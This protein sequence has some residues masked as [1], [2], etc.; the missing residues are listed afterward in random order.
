MTAREAARS[1]LAAGKALT[2]IRLSVI[3]GCD[4]RYCANVLA[5]M[6]AEGLTDREPFR[7]GKSGQ[8]AWEYRT[9]ASPRPRAFCPHC[10]G[11]L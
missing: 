8:P 1:A 9:A 7:S 2:A 3:T 6:H 5:R 11:D 10:G 4:E